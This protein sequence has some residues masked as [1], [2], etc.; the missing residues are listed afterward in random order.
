MLGFSS[1]DDP[2]LH[3]ALKHALIGGA[4]SALVM[5][6]IVAVVGAVGAGQAK[7]LLEATLPTT[8]FLCSS[9]MTASA[10]T[11]ALMLTMLSLS[12]GS[13]KSIKGSHYKRIQQIAFIDV[14]AFVAAT[15]L[16]VAL[17]IPFGENI[18]LPRWAYIALYYAVTLLSAL[19]GGVL[20][21]VMI[22]LYTAVRD[23]IGVFS[24]DGDSTLLSNDESDEAGASDS[25]V[26]A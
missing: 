9:V 23:L 4:V 25:R 3:V 11:L 22:M 15:V 16:L 26:D 19:L 20:V 1:D 13:D 6:S 7:I 24:P 10:T 17:V 8:R 21:S 12:A 2:Q 18:S 14:I 5:A